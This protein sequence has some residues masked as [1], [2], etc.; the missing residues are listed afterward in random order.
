MRAAR[1]PMATDHDL[2]EQWA[3]EMIPAAAMACS[4][5]PMFN[6]GKLDWAAGASRRLLSPGPDNPSRDLFA[7]MALGCVKTIWAR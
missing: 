6:L 2:K 4:D 3:R 5:K 7:A 1:V